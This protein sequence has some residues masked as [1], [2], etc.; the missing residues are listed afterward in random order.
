MLE[1][2]STKQK[3]YDLL[4]T[5]SRVYTHAKITIL[6]LV[7]TRVVYTHDVCVYFRRRTL[8]EHIAHAANT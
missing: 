7:F 3:C 1:V 4:Y 5:V 8:S 6:V 2:D